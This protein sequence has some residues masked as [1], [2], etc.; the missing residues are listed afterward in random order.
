MN[1][2]LFA[3]ASSLFLTSS[4]VA[5][6]PNISRWSGGTAQTQTQGFSQG[7]PLRLT[8][9]FMS[10][11]AAINGDGR[12]PDGNNNLQTR[13]NTIYAGGQAE[14]QPLFQSVFD[15]W[16]SISGLSYTFEAN[17][18]GAA[19]SNGNSGVLGTRAD[20]RI[21]GKNLDGNSGV[22]AYNWFPNRADMVIDTNDNFFSNTTNNSIRLRN[23][24]SHEHGHGCGCF[25]CISS[26]SSQNFLMEP[27]IDTSFD[28]PQF[29]DILV[30]QRG[31]GDALERS[32]TFQGNDTA[33]LATPLGVV[34]Q[35]TPVSI[36]NSPKINMANGNN[37]VAPSATDFI[38]LDSDTDTDFYSF[39]VTNAATVSILLEAL[40]I[41]YDARPEGSGTPFDF[42]TRNR[43]DMTLTLFDT[44]G[45]TILQ[46]ANLNGF[47][48][49][50][51]ILFNL[52]SAGTYFVRVNGTSNG[53]PVAL[54]TQ[55]YALSMV[56]VAVPEPA[57]IALMGGIGVAIT[58]T[59]WNRRRKLQLQLNSKI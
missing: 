40:G 33:T 3:S 34:A 16:S 17:D 30:I 20:V 50:E 58:G 37:L 46:T 59:W 35:A 26:S 23:V 42:N 24:V 36:G 47:G 41:T 13:L 32:N 22:L 51:S 6:P 38:S 5:Q 4:L 29:H 15:R 1:R 53:D 18:D 31:Y 21:G 43:V 28:G 39:S 48:G 10:L 25:H 54:D 57:T 56:L 12:F 55:F 14:W 2:L 52:L 19:A 44:N 45:T 8:W 7:S 9:G 49:D 27:F 11:G